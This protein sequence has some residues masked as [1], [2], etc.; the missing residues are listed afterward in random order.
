VADTLL[1]RPDGVAAPG[2]KTTAFWLRLTIASGARPGIYRG[3]LQAEVDGK[4][5]SLPVQVEVFPFALADPVD[6][7]RGL[8][9]DSARWA[10]RSDDQA[11]RELLDTRSHGIESLLLDFEKGEPTWQG[12]EITGWTIAYEGE[13]TMALLARAGLRGPNLIQWWREEYDFARKL[14][15][16]GETMKQHADEWPPKLALTYRQAIKAFDAAWK[17]KGWGDWVYVGIDEPGYWKPGSPEFSRFEYDAAK[18]ADVKSYCT[19]SDLPSDPIGRPLTYHCVGDV[20]V[21]TPETA[22]RFLDEGKQYGQQ[23]WFYGSGCY[24]GQVGNV[25]SNRYVA[26]FLFYKSGAAGT[27]SWTFQRP[28]GSNAFDDF[29]QEEGQ[30]CITIPDPEHPGENLDTPQWEGLRQAWYDYRYVATL[31][32]EIE[33]A[34]HD[35]NRA[36]LVPKVESDFSAILAAMLWS[37][38]GSSQPVI[39]SL[40]CD[41]WRLRIARLVLALSPSSAQYP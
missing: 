9:S 15:I 24:S 29:L 1:S 41:G 27:V 6:R 19:S 28:M 26:G 30:P 14:G 40:A 10:E 4:E 22:K 16:P 35:Q 5:L 25:Y 23:I 7:T 11:L 8:Y 13:R 2:G 34:R 33:R 17:K 36:S 38:Q 39:T 20:F 12:E 21:D 3:T 18:A 32:Q 31:A 37:P